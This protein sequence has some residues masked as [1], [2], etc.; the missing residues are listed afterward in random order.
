MLEVRRRA[1]RR[2]S[3][4]R[5][6]DDETLAPELAREPWEVVVVVYEP[7]DDA[8]A[9]EVRALELATDALGP[10][11][12]LDAHGHEPHLARRVR[13]R[14]PV[15]QLPRDRAASA[16]AAVVEVDNRRRPLDEGGDRKTRDRAVG[17]ESLDVK[18]RHVLAREVHLDGSVER[19]AT[20]GVERGRLREDLARGRMTRY[21]DALPNVSSERAILRA[22]DIL[23]YFPYFLFNSF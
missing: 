9:V 1:Q 14:R 6:D 8:R 17:A 21:E 13:A 16:S 22:R 11:A 18:V 2:E 20:R 3:S 23:F 15:A 4:A 5:V 19:G 10:P 12:A 7:V